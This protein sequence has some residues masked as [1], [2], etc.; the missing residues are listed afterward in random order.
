MNITMTFDFDMTY[1]MSVA[2]WELD[3]SGSGSIDRVMAGINRKK[4]GRYL[5]KF[6]K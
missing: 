5:A 3:L 4:V 2:L 1:D 6:L